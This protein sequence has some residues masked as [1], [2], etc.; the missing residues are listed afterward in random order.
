MYFGVGPKEHKRDLYGFDREYAGLCE[1]ISSQNRLI[2]VKGLRRTGKTSL[3]N[4]VYANLPLSKI[5]IDAREISGKGSSE[6][7]SHFITRL[8]AYMQSRNI[9]SKIAGT[10]SSVELGVKLSVQ[11]QTPLLSAMLSEIDAQAGKEKKTFCIF[12]DEAQMLKQSGFDAFLAFAYDRF[13]NTKIILA[14]SE[15]GLLDEFAGENSRSP[16]Y[17]RVKKTITTRKFERSESVDFLRRGFSQAGK[18]PAET[19]VEDAVNC[20]DGTAGWLSMYGFYALSESHASALAKTRREGAKIVREEI[21]AFMVQRRVAERQYLAILSALATEPLAWSKIR[22]Y[23][24]IRLGKGVSDSRLFA[25]LSALETYGF[26]EKHDGKYFVS[27]PL[28]KEAAGG[29]AR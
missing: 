20:L 8:S 28:I 11:R 14:G 15:I 19:D 27:D 16:L 10:I 24:E 23:L 25:Y 9:L 6:V 12:I 3:L 7:Y 1:A 13:K 5:F 18:K 21:N 2:I 4:S 29:N 17:G 22:N 26:I